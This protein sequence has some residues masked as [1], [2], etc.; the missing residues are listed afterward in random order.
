M[1]R[2]RLSSIYVIDLIPYSGPI[3]GSASN[4]YRK[5]RA[6]CGLWQSES[7]LRT[8]HGFVAYQAH[9]RSC[10]FFHSCN[11]IKEENV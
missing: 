11:E 8:L 5:I 6:T 9:Q 2:I 10:C 4:I 7:L 1:R 3:Y